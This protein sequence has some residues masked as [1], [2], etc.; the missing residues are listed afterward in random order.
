MKRLL[1]IV[2]FTLNGVKQF[3]GLYEMGV[4]CCRK[5]FLLCPTR[6]TFRNATGGSHGPSPL[7]KQQQNGHKNVKN[8]PKE[9]EGGTM[10]EALSVNR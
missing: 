6:Q 10:E 2:V 7:K 3:P 9:A 5:E 8:S 1:F 4:M